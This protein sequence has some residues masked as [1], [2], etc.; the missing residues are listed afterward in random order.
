MMHDDEPLAPTRPCRST[1]IEFALFAPCIRSGA[2]VCTSVFFFQ[3]ED[4]IRDTSVTGVQTCALPISYALQGN[5]SVDPDLFGPAKAELGW[6]IDLLRGR[7]L[8][9][10]DEYHQEPT[11]DPKTKLGHQIGR[12]SCRERV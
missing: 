9:N 11:I 1:L 7:A 12:A 3:A 6:V 10:L 2:K 4:G 5:A 8:P